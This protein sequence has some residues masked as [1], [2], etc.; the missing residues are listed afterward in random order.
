MQDTY[1]IITAAIQQ[2]L[3]TD[4]AQTPGFRFTAQMLKHSSE[5]LYDNHDE[6]CGMIGAGMGGLP[7]NLTDEQL[8]KLSGMIVQL[9][10]NQYTALQ[11][12]TNNKAQSNV[13]FR[14]L[15]SR[16]VHQV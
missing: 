3:N 4:V 7:A 10:N 12:V 5:A 13:I 6:L 2:A 8:Y 11:Q 14:T 1:D 9:L 15:A 16:G